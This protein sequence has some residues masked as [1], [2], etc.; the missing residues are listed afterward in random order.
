MQPLSLHIF[1]FICWLKTSQI[2]SSSFLPRVPILQPLHSTS[3]FHGLYH[4]ACIPIVHISS[5]LIPCHTHM[6]LIMYSPWTLLVN[7]LQLNMSHRLFHPPPPPAHPLPIPLRGTPLTAH[8]TCS[9]RISHHNHRLPSIIIHFIHCYN[10]SLSF[11]SSLDTW[12][13]PNFQFK[14]FYVQV[15]FCICGLMITSCKGALD[16]CWE[17]KKFW[18]WIKTSL[19]VW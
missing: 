1:L 6:I 12:V 9:I 3:S 7:P 19:N 16:K 10:S 8:L 13:S 4:P 5:T 17:S 11:F 15:N 14:K 18:V 2:S